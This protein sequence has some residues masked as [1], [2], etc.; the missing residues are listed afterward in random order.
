M[1]DKPTLCIYHGKDVLATHLV[2][3]RCRDES[4]GWFEI[5]GSCEQCTKTILAYQDKGKKYDWDCDRCGA[6]CERLIIG[7]V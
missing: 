6:S 3:H 1:S 5:A 2:R 7:K 4:C